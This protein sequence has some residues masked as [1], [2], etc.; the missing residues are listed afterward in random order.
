MKDFLHTGDG[1]L[2]LGILVELVLDKQPLFPSVL[3]T[4]YFFRKIHKWILDGIE[5]RKI[6]EEHRLKSMTP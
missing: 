1:S 6:V 4:P 2:T 5:E 3:E